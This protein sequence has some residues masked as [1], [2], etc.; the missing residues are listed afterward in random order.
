MPDHHT[1]TAKVNPL[2]GTASTQ[3]PQPSDARE[4]QDSS[5]LRDDNRRFRILG[6]A[7]QFLII[8]AIVFVVVKTLVFNSPVQ[9]KA[10][11]QALMAAGIGVTVVCLIAWVMDL[12][13]LAR[14]N[15]T[16]AKLLWSVLIASILGNSAVIYKRQAQDTP[17]VGI[18]CVVPLVSFKADEPLVRRLDTN[19]KREDSIAFFFSVTGLLEDENGSYSAALRFSFEDP[20]EGRAVFLEHA[21]SG[22][23]QKFHTDPARQALRNTFK[24]I[25]PECIPE[26]SIQSAQS[27]RFALS[28]FPA[29]VY[30][31]NVTIVDRN[32]ST[33]AT[34]P[35]RVQLLD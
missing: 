21:F 9:Q 33:V 6:L 22:N 18:A 19:Y 26:G 17:R 13:G 10:L 31:L 20:K 8:A 35:L 14:L 29:G 34:S 15:S 3:E 5:S 2:L 25:A 16:A 12:L 32:G 23:A 30:P 1:P 28:S 11:E 27:M 4:T 7:L 24:A